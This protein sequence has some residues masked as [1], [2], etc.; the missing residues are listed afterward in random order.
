MYKIATHNSATGEA[1]VDIFHYIVVPFT[2]NQSKT[3]S[4]Q[5]DA[6]VRMFDLRV[7][8]YNGQYH[9]GHGLFTTKRSFEDITRQINNV[10]GRVYATI[11][12]EGR[13]C[14]KQEI[15]E[16]Y[17]YVRYIT[18]CYNHIIWGDVAVKY[19]NNDLIVDWLVIQKA[20]NRYVESESKFLALDGKNWQSYIPIPWLWKKIYYDKPVFNNDKFTYIDFL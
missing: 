3:I 19:T 17:D 4:Q 10:S 1:P 7:K 14:S 16:F 13:L 15:N 20:D 8:K 18:I 9:S 5:I 12:Y 11:T 2:R 6:G